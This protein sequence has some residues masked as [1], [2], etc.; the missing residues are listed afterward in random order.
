MTK[1]TIDRRD[2][3]S[4]RARLEA[5]LIEALTEND[6]LRVLS[7]LASAANQG[8][9]AGRF[10]Q[11]FAEERRLLARVRAWSRTSTPSG[12]MRAR[13]VVNG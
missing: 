2:E 7:E 6:D 1:K 11:A 5:I 9:L 8:A 4:D 12:R 13:A 3:R 10:A